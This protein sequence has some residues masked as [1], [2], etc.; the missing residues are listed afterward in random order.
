M[1]IDWQQFKQKVMSQFHEDHMEL[2]PVMSEF[3]KLKADL[4]ACIQDND[5]EN[6]HIVA[7]GVL[8]HIAESTTLTAEQ[9]K[10]LVELWDQVNKWYS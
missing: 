3:D 6:A 5:Q 9:R 4:E 1:N 7:D 10:E 8:C 2:Q